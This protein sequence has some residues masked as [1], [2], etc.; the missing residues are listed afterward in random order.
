M[1]HLEVCPLKKTQAPASTVFDAGRH[2]QDRGTVPFGFPQTIVGPSV[3]TGGSI[4]NGLERDSHVLVL[5]K[6]QVEE[7]EE[8]CRCFRGSCLPSYV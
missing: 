6:A 3:W 5:S 7:L 4:R 1:I 2:K 8:A